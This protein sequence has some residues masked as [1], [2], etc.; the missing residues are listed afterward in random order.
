MIFE[1][2][3]GGAGGSGEPRR[4]QA[5]LLPAH[6]TLAALTLQVKSDSACSE[7]PP[8]SCR[9]RRPIHKS[10][11]LARTIIDHQFAS[12]PRLAWWRPRATP[13]VIASRPVA[14]G[15]QLTAS[16]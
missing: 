4:E 5:S 11:Q 6:D 3:R 1:L 15:R 13:T 12:Y 16:P 8:R 2:M 14:R 7:R 10:A 9:A